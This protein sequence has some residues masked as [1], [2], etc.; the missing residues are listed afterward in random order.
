[1]MQQSTNK[2][3]SKIIY[4]N[5]DYTHANDGRQVIYKY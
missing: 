4:E 5:Q 1:M 2:K 3:A